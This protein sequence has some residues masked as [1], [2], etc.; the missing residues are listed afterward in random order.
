M[1]S[2]ILEN[3]L[4]LKISQFTVYIFISSWL[5]AEIFGLAFARPAEPSAIPIN[6]LVE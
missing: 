4:L 6:F 5:I 3:L 2:A 1:D